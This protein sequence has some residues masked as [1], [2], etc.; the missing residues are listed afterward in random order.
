M[1][2]KPCASWIFGFL[3]LFLKI[4]FKINFYWSIVDL[5]FVLVSAVQQSEIFVD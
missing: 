3:L 1:G 2:H 4:F 5:Q